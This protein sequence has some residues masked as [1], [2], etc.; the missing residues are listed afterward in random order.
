MMLDPTKKWPPSNKLRQMLQNCRVTQTCLCARWP[1]TLYL[2]HQTYLI[3]YREVNATL[4]FQFVF[5][6]RILRHCLPVDF[7][8][9]FDECTKSL[10]MIL[11]VGCPLVERESHQLSGISD[12]GETVIPIFVSYIRNVGWTYQR[13]FKPI[14]MQYVQGIPDW[15]EIWYFYV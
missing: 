2:A 1:L 7:V 3:R 14:Y 12:R 6:W 13:W 11:S 15:W 8:F 5:P 9:S 4:A 10:A